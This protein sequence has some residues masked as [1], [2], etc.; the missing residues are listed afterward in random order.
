MGVRIHFGLPAE[1]GRRDPAT[2]VKR[3]LTGVRAL[4]AK[5]EPRTLGPAGPGTKAVHSD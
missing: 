4:L 2:P 1:A 5:R 3:P